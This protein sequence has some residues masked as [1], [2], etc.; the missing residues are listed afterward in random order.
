VTVFNIRTQGEFKLLFP[1]LIKQPQKLYRHLRTKLPLFEYNPHKTTTRLQ[2]HLRQLTIIITIFLIFDKRNTNNKFNRGLIFLVKIIDVKKLILH[3]VHSKMTVT[4]ENK[5]LG[6]RPMC[7]CQDALESHFEMKVFRGGFGQTGD[8]R[9]PQNK[10]PAISAITASFPYMHEVFCGLE[11]SSVL[12][13]NS[14]ESDTRHLSLN[15]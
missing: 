15:C 9:L 1:N 14:E 11:P 7:L 4:D 8:E 6:L 3:I 10:V 12:E 2:K 13:M 5:C